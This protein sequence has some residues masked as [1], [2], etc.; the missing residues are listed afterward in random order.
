MTNSPIVSKQTSTEVLRK[1]RDKYIRKLA[2]VQAAL[3]EAL[4]EEHETPAMPSDPVVGEQVDALVRRK[5]VQ[6]RFLAP[7]VPTLRPAIVHVFGCGSV[8]ATDLAP[9]GSKAEMSLKFERGQCVDVLSVDGTTIYEN[10]CI[11]GLWPRVD[12]TS[13][14]V[15]IKGKSTCVPFD[16][17]YPIGWFKHGR[18]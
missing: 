1:K 4:Q 6:A 11:G 13:V 9:A 17:V 18:S 7:K 14:V 3:Q 2:A 15:L 8:F 12:A 10:L 5:W 16:R